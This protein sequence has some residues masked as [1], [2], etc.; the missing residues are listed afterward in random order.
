MLYY[1]LV[2]PHDSCYF[3]LFQWSFPPCGDSSLLSVLIIIY[4]LFSSQNKLLGVL[5]LGGW[6]NKIKT[7]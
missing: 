3:P 1:F 6:C 2:L 5:E 7:K 4:G